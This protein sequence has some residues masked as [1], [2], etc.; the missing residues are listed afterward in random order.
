M[1]VFL[2]KI[3]KR[4][5]AKRKPKVPWITYSLLKCIRRKNKLYKKYLNKPTET[6][7]TTFKMYRNK[8]NSLL[9]LAKQNYFSSKLDK[10][11]Y[12]TR[13]T[14]KVLNSILRSPK[15]KCCNKFVRENNTYTDSKQIAN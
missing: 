3:I 4:H 6:N 1:S 11:R 14:W 7:A 15:K 12:N 13:N 9:K 2:K 5:D 8:L 10:E